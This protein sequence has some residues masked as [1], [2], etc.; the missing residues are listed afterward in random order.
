MTPWP[1]KASLSGAMLGE[2][3]VEVFIAEV[4]HIGRQCP[5]IASSQQ[6]LQFHNFCEIA[7][8]IAANLSGL[9]GWAST[10]GASHTEP[11]P[12]ASNYLQMQ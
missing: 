9:T 2:L 5:S 6:P 4:I 7:T 1:V 8:Q 11:T 10:Y 3:L 12:L